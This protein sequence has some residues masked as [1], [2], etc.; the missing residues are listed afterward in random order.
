MARLPSRQSRCTIRGRGTQST[1]SLLCFDSYEVILEPLLPRG[2]SEGEDSA[3]QIWGK[4]VDEG[5]AN[6]LCRG[7]LV[8]LDADL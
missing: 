6:R 2:I 5:L 7:S 4:Q 1:R 8:R 3:W